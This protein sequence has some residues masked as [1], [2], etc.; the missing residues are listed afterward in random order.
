MDR[1]TPRH[2]Q[3]W[4]LALLLTWLALAMP[5]AGWQAQMLD[6]LS[7]VRATALE[8]LCTPADNAPL[9]GQLLGDDGWDWQPVGHDIPNRGFSS[10]QCWLRLALTSAADDAQWVLVLD[11]PLLGQIDLYQQLDGLPLLHQQAGLDLAWADRPL[12]SNVPAFPLTLRSGETTRV[13]VSVTSAHGILLPLWLRPAGIHE[14]MEQQRQS[15]QWAFTGAMLVMVAW[16]AVLFLS[17]RQRAHMLYLCWLLAM[18]LF[19]MTLHGT[20][21]RLL[22]PEQPMI[23]KHIIVL[24]LPLL[25]LLPCLFTRAFLQLAQRAPDADQLLYRLALC[26][27]G[28]LAATAFVDR[29]TM[30]VLDVLGILAAVGAVTLVA[31]QRLR[32]GD[33]DARSFLMGWAALLLGAAAMALCRLGVLPVNAVTQNLL[34]LGIVTQV[35]LL[36]LTV[37]N[38]IH[39]L[40]NARQLAEAATREITE[41]KQNA[42]NEAR[43]QFLV[44]V[45]QQMR[46]PMN[47]IMGM[48]DLLRRGKRLD[49]GARTQAETIYDAANALLHSLNEL[50]DYSSLASGEVAIKR[51]RLEVDALLSDVVDLFA[52]AINNK[53]LA[54]HTYI[55]S[56]VPDTI[57]SDENRLKQIL[58]N[59]LS[60]AVKYSSSGDITL[61]VSH[62]SADGAHMLLIEICDQGQGMDDDLLAALQRDDREGEHRNIGITVTRRLVTLLGGRLEIR[63][64]AG[65]GTCVQLTV[66]CGQATPVSR[67]DYDGT[68]LLVCEKAGQRLALSQLLSRWGMHSEELR[69]LPDATDDRDWSSVRLVILDE[70]AY[71]SLSTQTT[72]PARSVP[73]LVLGQG[74]LAPLQ[75]EDGT[76]CRVLPTPLRPLDLRSQLAQCMSGTTTQGA[77]EADRESNTLRRQ[78]IL[79]VD[80]D[81]VSQMVIASLLKS[82][83]MQVDLAS[84]GEDAVAL[85][86]EKPGRWQM[87]FLDCEMPGMNGVETLDRIRALDAAFNQRS[88][89]AALTAHADQQTRKLAEDAGVDDFL[90]KPVSRE[91]LFKA[92]QRAQQ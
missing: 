51:S 2:R 87:V 21:Q 86:E 57:T 65:A 44:K 80:D 29:H 73:Q 49:D 54:L 40:D 19:M 46:T 35:V 5:A 20:G 50:L 14:A 75:A 67:L 78:N 48:A 85:W 81:H 1:D 6:G 36:A 69:A 31:V 55:E 59:L 91:M 64:K 74:A 39:S 76:S 84:S 71:L 82:L 90:T 63:S 66:P 38:R 43:A 9:P 92:L 62:R 88:W 28:L 41:L 27:A 58:I 83:G 77:A 12:A 70:S 8:M 42:V 56:R 34:Q 3:P 52:P 13:L 37:A 16:H 11:D 7:A 79:V 26:G 45:S 23:G 72:H 4:R 22:W 61:S 25:M 33:V 89:V 53:G 10:E 68:V 32:A 17:L 24:L 18:T 60:N 15:V 47:A 30:V